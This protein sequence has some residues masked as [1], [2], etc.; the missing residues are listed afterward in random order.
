MV[1]ENLGEIWGLEKEQLSEVLNA[2]LSKEESQ[3]LASFDFDDF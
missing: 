2:E 1:A 3:A